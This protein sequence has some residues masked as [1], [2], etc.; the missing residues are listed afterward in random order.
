MTGRM[1]VG[2][3]TL[4]T[5]CIVDRRLNT[6]GFPSQSSTIPFRITESRLKTMQNLPAPPRRIE[7][8]LVRNLD[9]LQMS[10]TSEPRS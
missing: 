10:Y 9:R 2:L 4:T 5:E 7:S 3:Y 6:G 1:N 8:T